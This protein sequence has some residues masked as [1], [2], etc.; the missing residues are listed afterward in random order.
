M[1]DAGLADVNGDGLLAVVRRADSPR[2]NKYTQSSE[3]LYFN[4]MWTLHTDSGNSVYGGQTAKNIYLGDHL[5]STIE[6]ENEIRE[7]L[8]LELRKETNNDPVKY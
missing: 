6:K 3:T 2:T 5:G 4:K 1:N 8:N 7:E